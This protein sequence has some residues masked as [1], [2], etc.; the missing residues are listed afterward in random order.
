[1]LLGPGQS[2]PNRVKASPP[3]ASPSSSFE[4]SDMRLGGPR[5]IAQQLG[6]RLRKWCIGQWRY[7]DAMAIIESLVAIT[8]GIV[9]W[10]GMWDLMDNH[11]LPDTV[12]AKL[13]VIMASLTTLFLSRTLYDKELITLRANERRR[14]AEVKLKLALQ[15]S[16]I[17][18]ADASAAPSA[19]RMSG[20]LQG[21][22]PVEIEIATSSWPAFA[23]APTQ[24]P[25]D[26]MRRLYFDAPPFSP[27][28]FARAS[29]ALLSS[30]ALWI[31]MWDLLDYHLIPA[32]FASCR[33]D[34]WQCAFVKA[35]CV[36]LGLTGLYYT[37]ALYG[38]DRVKSAHFSR[39]A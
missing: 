33:R 27:S 8:S 36:S 6:A 25:Q 13:L 11:L 23:A 7:F 19:H 16:G 3:P 10:L 9:V 2:M 17:A 34:E 22:L 18:L 37:R 38:T 30:L 1:M 39:M 35:G 26:T 31:G 4:A 24:P 28:L 12:A 29:L 21:G 14:R 5:S 20:P 15:A 32:L